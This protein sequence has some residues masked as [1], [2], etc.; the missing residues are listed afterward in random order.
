MLFGTLMGAAQV[1]ALD[2]SGRELGRVEVG[3]GPA[4]LAILPSGNSLVV[5]NR[6]EASASLVTLSSDGALVEGARIHL[7]G[8][9]HP[10]GVALNGDGSVAYVSYEGTTE[11]MGGVVALDVKTASEVWRAEVGSFTLGIAWSRP[12]GASP[13]P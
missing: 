1:V 5:A 13:I 6:G 7:A 2:R 11:T 10:H 4:Q 9:D 3:A 8:A 12:T